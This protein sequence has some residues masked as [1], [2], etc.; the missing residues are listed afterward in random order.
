[1]VENGL[2]QLTLEEVIWQVY[3]EARP[4]VYNPNWIKELLE[5]LVPKVNDVPSLKKGL[6]DSIK[7]IDD[8]TK[9]TDVSI[10]ISYLERAQ[11]RS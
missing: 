2:P 7:S 1:M 4:Y 11:R 9:R 10:Y 3:S 8:V 5:S 6:E